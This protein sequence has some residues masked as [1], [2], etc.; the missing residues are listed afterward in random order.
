MGVIS[1]VKGLALSRDPSMG[2]LTQVKTERQQPHRA[3]HP[4]GDTH[5]LYNH[6]NLTKRLGRTHGIMGR[7]RGNGGYGQL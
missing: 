1:I 2:F 3:K 5:S 6:R 4:Y 7:Q